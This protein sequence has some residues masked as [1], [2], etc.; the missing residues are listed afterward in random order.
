[1]DLRRDDEAEMILGRAR[2][3]VCAVS[4]MKTIKIKFFA[5][6]LLIMIQNG[7]AQGFVNLNFEQASIPNATSPG[8]LIPISDGFPGW[9]GYFV[10]STATNQA[11]QAAYDGFSLGGSEISINDTNT[12]SGFVPLQGNY[13]AYLFGGAGGSAVISQIGLVPSGTKS[14]LID[15]QQSASSFN[16]PFTVSLNGQTINLV[17]L[18]TFPTY[19]LYG[20]D[21]SSFAGLVSTLTLVN[22]PTNKFPSQRSIVRRHPIFVFV[23]SRT[24]RICLGR[25]WSLAFR[26]PSLEKYERI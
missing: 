16:V 23:R 2:H 14:L 17:S 12:G 6:F 5:L 1:M 13:S 20:G 11:T 8:S 15:I 7:H 22:P 25:T 24:K 4:D 9:S 26:L 3:S 21:V 10:S 18:Q 19:I